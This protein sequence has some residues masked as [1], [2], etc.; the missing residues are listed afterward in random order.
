MSKQR[1]IRRYSLII[2]KVKGGFYPSFD[3]LQGYLE[4]FDFEISSRTLQRDIAAIRL[5][6]RLEIE[7]DRDRNGYYID[8]DNSIDI[9]S[10]FRFL[11]IVNT[12]ELLTESLA[13]SRDALKHISFDMGGGF[14]GIEY[15][16]PLLSAIK[17]CKVITFKHTGFQSAEI[18]ECTI[19]P[20]LLKEYQNRWYIVGLFLDSNESR[21]FG[22]DR[23]E[24]LDIL[25]K[26]FKR[27]E[28]LNPIDLFSRTIGVVYSE[29]DDHDVVLTFTPKQGNYVKTLPWHR[30]Q[31]ILIDNEDELRIRLSVN[32][33]FEL[34]QMVLKQG[35][36]VKVL[37]PKWFAD[38]V[39]DR[40]NSA[41]KQYQ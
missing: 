18:K 30:S 13:E 28:K 11:E 25:A 23:I 22:I 1:T 4:K 17:D 8:Y 33:N 6:F 31:E 27:E 32:P 3:D 10:F 35:E 14:K 20:Y 16:K 26:K 9:D 29:E 39:K 15:L 21:T 12:A 34:L 37:E 7:Y 36:A 41:L 5:E 19:K 24:E 2:E 38:Q 40:L